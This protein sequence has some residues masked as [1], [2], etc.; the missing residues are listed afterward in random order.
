MD[1]V[2]IGDASVRI[3]P[4]V[5]GLPSE[6]D[7]VRDAIESTKPSV[8]G[9]SI[10]PE[11]LQTLRTYAG[12]PLAPDNFEEEVYVAGLSAWE[13]TV[14]PPPCFSEAIRAADRRKIPVEALDMDEQTYTENYVNTVSGLEVVFQ[15][16]MEKRLTR[17]RFR[18]TSPRD[19]VL[20]WDAEVNG[21][22][23]FARLQSRREAYM[24][25]RLRSVASSGGP[26][27]G[28]IEVERVKGVLAAL[29]G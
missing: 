24:A 1:E 19:F 7:A 9:L 21:S 29:R 25:T 17:K 10:G 14:K 18:A 15:G 28:V 22:P 16:R 2:R 12:G 8:V 23:G 13:P 4:V 6:A 20:E 11:E 27:L 26:V 3:L 5:R